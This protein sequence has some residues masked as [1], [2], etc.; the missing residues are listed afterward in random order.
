MS[1]LR[2]V[3]AKEQQASYI[4]HLDV[5]RTFQRVFP[6][7]G[8]SLRHSNGFHPHP[9][10]SILLPLPVGQSSE[11][12]ILDFETVEDSDG[13][14]VA[15]ALNGGLPAGLRV[16]GCRPPVHPARELA[17]LRA[18]L[19]LDYDGGVPADAAARI[20]TLFA[21]QEIL[22]E[23]RTKHK[24]VTELNIAPLIRSLTID[25]GAD[26]VRIETV[27]A[28]QDPGLNPAL[29]GAAVARHL[30]ELAPD[31]T[32]VRRKEIYDKEMNV[33]R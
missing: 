14:G 30:P 6:R 4:S 33:F 15:E 32:R 27:A 3:F 28:A 10:I 7:A 13:S 5:M 29:I 22:V 26:A 18:Q 19:E 1:K 31:F 23:K 2:L 12:E 16:L 25:G 9:L 20:R 21:Q 17:L 24:G 11:C 8:L